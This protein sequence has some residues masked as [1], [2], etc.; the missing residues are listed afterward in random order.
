MSKRFNLAMTVSWLLVIGW[1]ILIFLLSAQVADQSNELSTGIT[2]KLFVL[3]G[4]VFK[5]LSL[6]TFNHYIRKTA[7]FTIYL[8]LGLLLMHAFKVSHATRRG[9][10]F[11]TFVSG[12]VYAVSDEFHQSFV[13]GRGP[14][15]F[16]VIIDTSGVIVGILVFL[17]L[18]WKNIRSY[19]NDF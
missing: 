12:M 13:P 10:V 6:K 14:S 7:H 8:V 1:M 11:L 9:G 4:K 19:T 5:D 2:E 15:F 17:L 16:D 3:V 18:C